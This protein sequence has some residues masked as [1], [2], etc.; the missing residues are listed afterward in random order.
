MRWI[1]RYQSYRQ[2]GGSIMKQSV[3]SVVIVGVGGQGTLLASRVLG[4][5]VACAVAV[6]ESIK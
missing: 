3:K 1:M 2:A 6:Y 5:T 4:A